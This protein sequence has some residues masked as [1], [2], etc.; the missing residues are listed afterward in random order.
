MRIISSIVNE[1]LTGRCVTP[2]L[3]RLRP[4]SSATH[5]LSWAKRRKALR[6]SSL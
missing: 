4:G 5:P 2:G 1:D 6:Y 3:L